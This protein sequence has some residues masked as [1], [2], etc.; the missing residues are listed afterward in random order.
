MS[1]PSFAKINWTL[2]VLGKR[3]DGFHELFTV[4]QT[5]SI[6]D[7]LSF[8]ISDGLEM[9]CSDPTIPTDERNLVIRAARELNSVARTSHEARIRLVKRIP[10]PGGLGGGSS[11][12]AVALIGL[13]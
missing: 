6:S 2:R 10:S 9:V 1:L 11:N 8:Q 7:T 13:R 3:D 4:F 12:A 5:V